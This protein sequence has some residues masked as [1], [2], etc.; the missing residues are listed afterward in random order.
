MEVEEQTWLLLCS[1]CTTAIVADSIAKRKRI[2]RSYECPVCE[3]SD[4][5]AM[6]EE[7]WQPV[8]AIPTALERLGV[9]DYET[10]DVVLKGNRFKLLNE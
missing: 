9:D 7:T 3:A 5:N 6:G 1:D 8:T 10:V 4:E 2:S